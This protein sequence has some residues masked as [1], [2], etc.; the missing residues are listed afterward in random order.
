M[1]AF[2]GFGQVGGSQRAPRGL[3]DRKLGG[4]GVCVPV[5]CRGAASVLLCLLRFYCRFR[6]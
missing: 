4:H 3:K 5:A 6:K 1:E 2:E